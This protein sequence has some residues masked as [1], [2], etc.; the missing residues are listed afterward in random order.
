MRK[1]AA[2]PTVPVQL[3][4]VFQVRKHPGVLPVLTD[5]FWHVVDRLP[6]LPSPEAPVMKE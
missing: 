3:A 6:T 2:Q 1:D 5:Q 4:W